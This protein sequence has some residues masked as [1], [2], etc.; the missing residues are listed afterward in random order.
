MN[1]PYM[2]S[3]FDYSRSV[4]PAPEKDSGPEKT[5]TRKACH[6]CHGLGAIEI[7]GSGDTRDCPNRKCVD[8]MVIVG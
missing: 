7:P 5:P 1:K 4:A 8:G 3:E 2:T 6:V